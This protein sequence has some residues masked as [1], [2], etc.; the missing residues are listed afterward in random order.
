MYIVNAETNYEMQM[1][2]CTLKK[3]QTRDLAPYWGWFGVE[4]KVFTSEKHLINCL[5]RHRESCCKPD[6]WISLKVIWWNLFGLVRGMVLIHTKSILKYG[7]HVV[8]KTRIGPW[9][10]CVKAERQYAEMTLYL[11]GLNNSLE[12]TT[13]T[14]NIFH[15]IWRGFKSNSDIIF[16]LW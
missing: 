8:L 5:A 3:S 12:S 13:K 15:W 14:W 10:I 16:A 4:T 6:W 9:R 11:G 7:L 2:R 1:F